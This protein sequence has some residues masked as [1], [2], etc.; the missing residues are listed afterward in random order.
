MK[1]L[2]GSLTYTVM[3]K[4]LHVIYSRAD[5]CGVLDL[6]R[7][8]VRKRFF[9]R[10]G[11]PV[12]AVSNM[13]SEVLGRL[14][15]AD[16]VISQKDYERSLRVV[17]G[18]R[19]RHGEVL[20]SLGLVTQEVLNHYLDLQVRQRLW[21][22]FSWQ[23]G[24]YIYNTVDHLPE[25]ISEFPQNPARTIL[26][27]I[28]LGYYPDKRLKEDL[29]AYMDK[30]LIRSQKMG[31]YSIR[32]FGLNLQERRFL[33]SFDGTKPLSEI[34]K[35]SDLLRHRIESLV[36]SFILTEVIKEG[37]SSGDVQTLLKTLQTDLERF[38]SM[39]DTELFGLKEDTKDHEKLEEAYL[40]LSKKYRPEAF[41]EY[42]DEVRA[43]AG[44][45]FYYLTKRYVN[46]YST[47][48]EKEE[49]ER[50]ESRVNAEILFIK[51]RSAI[52]RRDLKEAEEI[53]KRITRLNPLEPEYR[54]YLGWVGFLRDPSSFREAE[55][56][57]RQALDIKADS[58][59]AWYFLGRILL[60]SG[61]MEK[62]RSSFQKALRYNPWF[63][64]ALRELK[65][66]ELREA[67]REDEKREYMDFFG[68]RED[69]ISSVPSRR[70][71]IRT[72]GLNK[73]LKGMAENLKRGGI[74]VYGPEGS[75]KTTLGFELL[76]IFSRKK[77][78]AVFLLDPPH[79]GLPLM[80]AI[81][82]ELG[83]TDHTDDLDE[84]IHTFKRALTI[85]M[86]KK[87]TCII[88][89]DQAHMLRDSALKLLEGLTALRGLRVVLIGEPEILKRL[90][91]FPSLRE[92][93]PTAYEIPPLTREETSIYILKRIE[94]AKGKISFTDEGIDALFEESRGLP[95][96]INRIL[97]KILLF[98]A[99]SASTE[100]VDRGCVE[101]ALRGGCPQ[102][103]RP[104]PSI[105]PR[106]ESVEPP[107]R[108][109]GGDMERDIT[110]DAQK[111]GPLSIIFLVIA[112]FIAG[113]VVGSLIGI[114]WWG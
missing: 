36:L 88:I 40:E 74:V 12:F 90:E 6:Q 41:S 96:G 84:E 70:F 53:L 9:F 22:V 85:N 17:L 7:P 68:F 66:I 105:A 75:G 61:N 55:A 108:P 72:E 87:G 44:E 5:S 58:D 35:G 18:E 81:N 79:D 94:Q 82:R 8:P 1:E 69:P 78:L 43:L 20:L 34:L 32:D 57:V 13:L 89:L 107:E 86:A 10:N 92:R 100:P 11:T 54:A 37:R 113:L 106:E 101:N 16:G 93:I 38:K 77:V 47:Q 42:Q 64:E 30:Y 63:T 59:S 31:R 104:S 2:Q 83:E 23:K 50:E 103:K 51:A 76:G 25:D 49:E 110:I 56:I 14:L 39:D 95:G 24:T 71:F 91:P 4:L 28:Y 80:K 52:A 19:K 102:E 45:I 62:A 73:V 65:L 27:G 111:R 33:E 15:V 109:S 60:Y 3:P 112:L 99:H 26:N 114:I 48:K 29:S 46:L 98:Y 67:L 97:E 21:K